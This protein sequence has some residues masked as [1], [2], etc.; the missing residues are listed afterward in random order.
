M[1]ARGSPG[2][3]VILADLSLILFTVTASA[4]D[5]EEPATSSPAHGAPPDILPPDRPERL[6]SA[7][8]AGDDLGA[9]LST[10]RADAR[11][12]LRIVIHYRA[13]EIDEALARA[14]GAMRVSADA[15]HEAQVTLQ[16]GD[17][18]ET[19]AVFAFEGPPSPS[20]E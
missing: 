13:G 11:E 15:G 4:L 20:P 9:W 7:R 1:I 5:Y 3:Q 19:Q 10:Y 2:W 18:A 12:R 6:F 8:M 16:A 14:A 17:R